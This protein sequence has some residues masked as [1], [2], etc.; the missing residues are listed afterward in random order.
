MFTFLSAEPASFRLVAEKAE[1]AVG[2]P[3]V[4]ALELQLEKEWSAYW[5][6]PG[7]AGMAPQVEWKLPEGV[8]LKA[9]HWPTPTRYD[10]G[11]VVTYGYENKAIFVAEFEVSGSQ[12][13]AIGA[14]VRYVICSNETCL[15]GSDTVEL[16]GVD[17]ALVEEGRHALPQPPESLTV[18]TEGDQFLLEVKAPGIGKAQLLFIP[19]SGDE[20]FHTDVVGPHEVK[21]YTSSATGILVADGVGYLLGDETSQSEIAEG[22]SLSPLPS[23]GTEKEVM[24][25]GWALLLAFAGGLIMNLMP[26]VLPVISFK[27][28][29]FVKLS[30][31]SRSLLFKHSMAFTWGVLVSFWALASVLL[32]L[33][34]Y[35]ETVGWGFQLQVPLFNAVL[36]AFLFLFGLSLFGVFEMG[37][38][39]MTK[40]AES[41]G[42]KEGLSGSFLSGVL[43]TAVATPCTGPFLGTALGFAVTQ[44]APAALSI[45]TSLALGMALPY[46]ILGAFPQFLK[47][48]PK[49]GPWMV[50][51]KQFMGFLMVATVLWLLWVFAAQTSQLALFM[52]LG[53]LFLMAIGAWIYGTWGTP[54]TR[55]TFR[56]IAQIVAL[57]IVGYSL[58]AMVEASRL[59]PDTDETDFASGDWQ[60][61]DAAKVETLQSQG[62]PVFVDFTAKWC[63]IC[64]VNHLVLSTPS[65]EAAFKEKGVVRM[66]AD[67]TRNDPSITAELKKFG[68]SGVPLYVLYANGKT[69]ILPQVLTPPIVQEALDHVR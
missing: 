48:I 58:Y 3:Y 38:S 23:D 43:A 19:E 34:S 57:V 7:A 31:E 6:N 28:M 61:F 2:Q 53:A 13:P 8:T 64:Q 65:M 54:R 40:A 18:T 16:K 50:A 21:L 45:F 67:W 60:M 1:P 24:S 22:F 14:E 52:V 30:G 9:F 44:S 17:S 15:P 47:W 32:I 39:L 37:T 12:T 10:D 20:T 35:G 59:A 49:P 56:R 27:V 4:V 33:Q 42:R 29:N 25:L 26:C 55:K 68:R 41:E 69:E 51:F 66:K 11:G 36:A 46:L 5:K 62:I 63:L